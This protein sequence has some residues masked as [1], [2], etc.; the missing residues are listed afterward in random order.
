MTLMPRSLKAFA[1]ADVPPSAADCIFLV[2]F[3]R[4]LVIV[5]VETSMMSAA[6]ANFC[7]SSVL[8]PVCFDNVFKSSAHCAASFVNANSPATA[9]VAA[10]PKAPNSLTS[11]ALYFFASAILVFSFSRAARS[12]SIF[13]LVSLIWFWSWDSLSFSASRASLPSLTVLLRRSRSFFCS[14]VA[15]PVLAICL[16]IFAI[17]FSALV[18]S[19]ESSFSSRLVSLNDFCRSRSFPCISLIPCVSA[20]VLKVVT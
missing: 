6:Y 1:A 20:L 8:I 16:W 4:E 14:S 2:S 5:S 13:L 7:N 3:V 15:S 18:T 19:L 11:S 10:A 17:S 12:S 9:A